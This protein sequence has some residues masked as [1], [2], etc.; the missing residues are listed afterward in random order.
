M[1]CIRIL[2]FIGS[3]HE[4]HVDAVTTILR[5][6]EWKEVLILKGTS[7]LT[8]SVVRTADAP[9]SAPRESVPKRVARLM[10]TPRMV[11]GR[12]RVT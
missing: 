4:A 3:F 10:P 6:E 2:E 5:A 1:S 12:K 11:K 7:Q 9:V 8:T